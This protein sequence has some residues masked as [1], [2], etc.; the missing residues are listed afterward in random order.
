MGATLCEITD[1]S[2]LYA[3]NFTVKNGLQSISTHDPIEAQKG[4][5]MLESKCLPPK[6]GNAKHFYIK[7]KTI[8]K[9][10]SDAIFYNLSLQMFRGYLWSLSKDTISFC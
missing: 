4:G 6:E 7:V 10:L 2:Q 5:Q 3:E 9:I 8:L 1:I